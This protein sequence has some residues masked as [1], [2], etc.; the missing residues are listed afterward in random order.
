MSAVDGMKGFEGTGACGVAW[1]FC[2]TV[3]YVG[4]VCYNRL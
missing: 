1:W 4:I 3:V 2:N